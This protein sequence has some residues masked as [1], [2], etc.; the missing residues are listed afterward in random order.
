MSDGISG[1]ALRGHRKQVR[2]RFTRHVREKNTTPNSF[3]LSFCGVH[4]CTY[5]TYQETKLHLRS[6]KRV[7]RALQLK[8]GARGSTTATM[9]QQPEGGGSSSCAE[10]ERGEEPQSMQQQRQQ[11]DDRLLKER[12]R[13]LRMGVKETRRELRRSASSSKDLRGTFSATSFKTGRGRW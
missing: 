12:L 7:E 8:G 10:W 2:R 1:D 13:R 9:M 5:H 4:T 6:L 11:G 3:L